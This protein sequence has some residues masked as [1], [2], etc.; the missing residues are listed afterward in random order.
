M[1]KSLIYLTGAIALSACTPDAPPQVV[2]EVVT[3]PAVA[4]AAPVIIQQDSGVGSALVGAAVGAGL[5]A[6]IMSNRN[7]APAASITHVTKNVTVINKTVNV[8]NSA[9]APIAAKPET[10]KEPPPTAPSFKQPNTITPTPQVTKIIPT[11]TLRPAIP[12]PM[13]IRLSSPTKKEV[14][15]KK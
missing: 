11:Q 10:P 7:T 4:P 6:A 13:T 9:P 12:A 2:R 1:K 5:T 14:K 8:A 3:T 15:E